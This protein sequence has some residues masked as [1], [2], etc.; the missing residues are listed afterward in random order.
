[1]DARQRS[2]VHGGGASMMELVGVAAGTVL[3]HLYLRKRGRIFTDNQ[4]LFLSELIYLSKFSKTTSLFGVD[5][6][7]SMVYQ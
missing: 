7:R 1:M 5:T 3:L 4:P 6:F 2:H